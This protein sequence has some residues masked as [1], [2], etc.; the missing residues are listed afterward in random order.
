VDSDLVKRAYEDAGS[1]IAKQVG[2][3][4]ED[5]AKAL[6][7]FT[8]PIQLLATAQDRFDRWL[9]KVRNS[10]P[11]QYQVE[12][13]PQIAGPVLMNLRFMDEDNELRHLY[14]NLLEAAID[15]RFRNKAHPGVL[16]YRPMIGSTTGVGDVRFR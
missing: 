2:K 14:L 3:C 13:D 6:R 5:L 1:P 12:A 10:V 4:G 15:E 8:A 11:E 9:S 16:V 7:L